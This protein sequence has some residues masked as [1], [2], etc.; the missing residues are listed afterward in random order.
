MR[1]SCH[2]KRPVFD[3]RLPRRRVLPVDPLGDR[4]VGEAVAVEVVRLGLRVDLDG[5]VGAHARVGLVAVAVDHHG[6]AARVVQQQPVVA[7]EHLDA[8]PAHRRRRAPAPRTGS[9]DCP[10]GPAPHSAPPAQ[11]RRRPRAR[12]AEY[13]T[14]TLLGI[15]TDRRTNADRAA[16]LCPA[17]G[18]RRRTREPAARARRAGHGPAATRACA[19]AP[20]TTR[21]SRAGPGRPRR[22]PEARDD[23]LLP[24]EAPAQ[25]E[26][27]QQQQPGPVEHELSDARHALQRGEQHGQTGQNREEATLRGVHDG[28]NVPQRSAHAKGFARTRTHIGGDPQSCCVV[29]R[30]D[31]RGVSGSGPGCRSASPASLNLDAVRHG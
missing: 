21:A 17:R 18:P 14:E 1:W 29:T 9:W 20:A 26:A 16:E 12:L 7:V 4:R 28:P 2:W 25:Q 6:V 30:E 8:E 24:D 13:D 15:D 5:P 11:R 19:P 27:R 22:R 3:D 10:D 31:G 23:A